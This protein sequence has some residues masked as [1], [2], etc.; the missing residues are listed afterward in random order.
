VNNNGADIIVNRRDYDAVDGAADE[1]PPLSVAGAPPS[2][3]TITRTA[4][5]HIRVLSPA[6]RRGVIGLLFTSASAGLPAAAQTP[7]KFVLAW[8]FE[9]PTSAWTLAQTSGCFKRN[10]LDVTIDGG[11]GSGDAL[12][13]VAAGAYDIGIADFSA[14]VSF[15]ARHPNQRLIATLIMNDRAPMSV[16]VLKTSGMTKP[17]DIAGKRVADNVGE[18][19]REMFPA[20]AKANGIDANSIT[21]INVAPSLRE[22]M[23]VRGQ[24]DVAAGNFLTIWIGLHRVGLKERDFTLMPYADWGVDMM[25]NSVVTKPAWAAANVETLR[26]FNACGIEAIRTSILQPAVA[27]DSLKGYNPLVERAMGIEELEIANRVTSMTDYVK[28]HG[29]G[30]V[31]AGRVDKALSEISGALGIAKPDPAEVWTDAYLPP[32]RDRWVKP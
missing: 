4:L 19:S 22:V 13:K 25:G 8:T 2:K 1:S 3:P 30:A 21:W 26:K 10:G 15:N 20:F 17:Q 18:A 29:L 24:A 5:R 31:D 14:L 28:Q 9:P 16:G 27:V 6:L 11:R 7:I 12:S 32:E 23:L